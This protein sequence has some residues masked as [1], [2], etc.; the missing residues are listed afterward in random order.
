[1]SPQVRSGHGALAEPP[2][3]LVDEMVARYVD[4]R[5]DAA[6]AADVEQRSR[7]APAGEKAQSCS[8]YIAAL[9][10]EEAAALAYELAVWDVER[11]LQ[12]AEERPRWKSQRSDSA[13]GVA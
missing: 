11:W 6:T 9:D 8:A 4:W 10:Q 13:A 1:M 2:A 3:A 12:R 7:L 5:E